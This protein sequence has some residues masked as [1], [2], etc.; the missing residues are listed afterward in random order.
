M[1][2]SQ[3]DPPLPVAPGK[4]NRAQKSELTERAHEKA[5]RSFLAAAVG[6]GDDGHAVGGAREGG[7]ARGRRGAGLSLVLRFAAAA[8][9]V[10]GGGGA[11]GSGGAV[12]T[13]HLIHLPRVRHQLCGG[14][15]TTVTTATVTIPTRLPRRHCAYPV[16]TQVELIFEYFFVLTN[17]G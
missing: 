10:A 4:I 5:A 14:N 8:G 3:C 17:E 16:T 12:A 7:G 15:A 1:T 13:A 6:G 11:P 9:A 2:C